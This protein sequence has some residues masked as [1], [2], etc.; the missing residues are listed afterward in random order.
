MFAPSVPLLNFP[1]QWDAC[2]GSPAALQGAQLRTVAGED[3]SA[4]GVQACAGRQDRAAVCR[5]HR[6]VAQHDL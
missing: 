1:P 5:H 6:A 4:Q 2:R 3:V